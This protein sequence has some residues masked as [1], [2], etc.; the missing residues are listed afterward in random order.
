MNLF[1]Q[2]RLDP[3]RRLFLLGLASAAAA[4]ACPAAAAATNNRPTVDVFKNPSCGC[5]GAWVDHLKAAGFRVNVTEVP[6]TAVVRKAEGLA[7][8]FGSCHTAKVGGY[9]LEGHVPAR[10]VKRLLA[11]RPEALGLAV[12]GMPMGSPGMEGGGPR[13]GFQVLLVDRRG[14]DSVF[15]S[16]SAT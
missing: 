11:M 14:N 4:V 13:T 9:V 2:V 7:D 10:E 15:A 3:S 16:Y 1:H 5:C 8:R 12:P 6:D